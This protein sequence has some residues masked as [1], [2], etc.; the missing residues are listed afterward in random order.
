MT[1]LMNL[2]GQRFGRLTVIAEAQRRGKA[3][4]WLCRC[5]CGKEREYFLGNLRRG[6]SQSCGCISTE[7]INAY[8]RT[9]GLTSSLEYPVWY[10][11]IRRCEGRFEAGKHFYQDRGIKVCDR[12]KGE[13]GLLNFVEDMGP[14]P[15]Q[16]HSLDRIDNDG[17]Y[18]PNNCR[19]ATHL[20]QMGNIRSN[21]N[22]EYNGKIQCMAAWSR[23]TGISVSGI[24][25]RL[26]KG[27]SIEKALTTPPDIRFVRKHNK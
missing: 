3:R 16:K 9:H 2:V 4:Y 21:H 7:R 12:W 10:D 27:W 14:R 20:E 15:S 22:L 1:K 17:N 25:K 8:N 19:W 6:V 24:Q 26:K 13:N 5:D 23:E 11:M 18:E